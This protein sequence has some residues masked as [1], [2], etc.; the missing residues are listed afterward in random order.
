MAELGR[1]SLKLD[2]GFGAGMMQKF[3][4]TQGENGI[5]VNH[6]HFHIFPRLEE[7]SGLFPVPEPNDFQDGFSFAPDKTIGDLANKLRV[8]KFEH[9]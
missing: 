6:L 2:N 5:K 4:P 1:L 8:N 3:Q 9:P 7:E